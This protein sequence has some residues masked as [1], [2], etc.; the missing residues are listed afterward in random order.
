VPRIDAA[1]WLAWHDRF[2]EELTWRAGR[3][4]WVDADGTTWTRS[5]PKWLTEKDARSFVLRASTLVAV[6]RSG[7][8][9][10]RWLDV[11]VRRGYWA[12]NVAGHYEDGAPPNADGL[13][14]SATVW[15]DDT[16]RRLILLSVSC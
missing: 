9:E 11:A 3:Q 7:Y 10:L 6:E 5:R 1:R 2:V 14:Y 16:E 13:T 15:T 4:S 8:T 12:D